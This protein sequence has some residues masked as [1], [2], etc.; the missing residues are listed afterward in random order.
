MWGERSY[1]WAETTLAWVGWGA[2]LRNH[3]LHFFPPIRLLWG[4]RG[5]T[6][7]ELVDAHAEQHVRPFFEKILLIGKHGTEKHKYSCSNFSIIKQKNSLFLFRNLLNKKWLAIKYWL[8]VMFH[9][10]WIM[11][12]IVWILLYDLYSLSRIIAHVSFLKIKV[13]VWI[14]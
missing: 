3:L 14:C 7:L 10:L 2:W 8:I 9:I 1:F 11:Q 12:C 4:G 6:A 13:N 5:P